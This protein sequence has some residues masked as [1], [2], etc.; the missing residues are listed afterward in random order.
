MASREEML[1]RQRKKH[2]EKVAVSQKK[3]KQIEKLLA[4]EK[5]RKDNR[6]KFIAGG[7][8]L[9]TLMEG[10][11]PCQ[12][13]EELLQILDKTLTKNI[14]RRAFDLPELP[15]KRTKNRRKKDR[16]QENQPKSTIQPTV[17]RLQTTSL[18]PSLVSASVAKQMNDHSPQTPPNPSD[19]QKRKLLPERREEDLIGEF[20]L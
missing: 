13:Y 10:Q 5:R 20:N 12:T 17:K 1:L 7:F 16:T 6:R 14:D 3:A 15:E 9:K 18:P 19:G 11:T 2:L 4:T 8:L